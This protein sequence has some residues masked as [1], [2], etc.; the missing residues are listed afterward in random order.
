MADPKLEII[1][2]AQ[3]RASKVLKGI[4]G[5]FSGL[6][7]A[8]TSPI[9]ALGSL[10]DGLGK[11]GL[12]GIG[13][14][15]LTQGFAGLA[16]GLVSGNGEMERYETQLGTLMGSA[17]AAKERLAELAKFGASTPFELPEIAK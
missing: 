16:G 8:A 10:T 7:K 2:E 4:S 9:K 6:S 5:G 12:A 15:G 17:D 13:L 3:D 14:Q 1:I 11:L